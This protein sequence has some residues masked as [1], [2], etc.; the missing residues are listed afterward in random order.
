MSVTRT[1]SFD[2]MVGANVRAERARRRLT[3]TELA[4][5]IGV[6][7]TTYRHLEAGRRSFRAKQL[8]AIASAMG[9]PIH[10][11][12]PTVDAY[13]SRMTKAKEYTA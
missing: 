7:R 1:A 13:A 10:I 6:G 12:L 5:L 4:E 2:E 9:V 11:F 8:D 3:T